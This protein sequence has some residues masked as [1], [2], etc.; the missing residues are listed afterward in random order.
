MSRLVVGSGWRVRVGLQMPCW[1]SA[2][3]VCLV[4]HVPHLIQ[5]WAEAACVP[6]PGPSPQSQDPHPGRG[7]GSCRSGDGSLNPDNDPERVC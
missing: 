7:N 5:R 4:T 3:L 2:P 1:S 6:G